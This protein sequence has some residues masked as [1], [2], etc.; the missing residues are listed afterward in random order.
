MF[1]KLEIS[2]FR[3][4]TYFKVL[5]DKPSWFSFN[6]KNKL[7]CCPI[8][9][10]FLKR[11]SSVLFQHFDADSSTV[12]VAWIQT[13]LIPTS[14]VIIWTV[15]GVAW[16]LFAFGVGTSKDLC[17]STSQSCVVN[18]NWAISN[19]K[20]GRRWIVW[21]DVESLAVANFHRILL[22]G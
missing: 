15:C 18:K 4:M 1:L 6:G 8:G 17:T 2:L 20:L 19:F 21:D 22:S 11:P 10:N 16:C 14:L 12:A 13:S 5:E 3:V 9:L 7:H